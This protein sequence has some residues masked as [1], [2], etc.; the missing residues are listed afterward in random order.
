MTLFDAAS[1]LTP[2]SSTLPTSVGVAIVSGYALDFL[3]RL[4]TLPQVNY[5]TT[6]L[7]AIVRVVLSG[8]GTL[9]VSW[10]WSAA[11]AG[12]QLLITIPAWSAVGVGVWH[13]AVQYGLQH[14]FEGVLQVQRHLDAAVPNIH[15]PAA[16]ENKAA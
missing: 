3:K 14:G 1:T 5:Y 8:I 4:K 9:G 10:A 11:G 12:H 13:W 6:T 7:N 16:L 2:I 15:S